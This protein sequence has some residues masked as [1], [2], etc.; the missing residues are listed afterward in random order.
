[1]TSSDQP[2]A[3]AAGARDRLRRRDLLTLGVPRAAASRIA[4]PAPPLED[5]GGHWIRVY[6]AAMACRFEITLAGEDARH[7]PAARDALHEAD[8]LE[9][10]LPGA[11]AALGMLLI[12][13]KE[14]R[15]ALLKNLLNRT[16]GTSIE[17]AT[18]YAA[19]KWPQWQ[20][21]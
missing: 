14:T 15:A 1:M 9:A 7:V 16:K 20:T 12:R 4:S 11:G 2:V 8:R 21:E 18:R 13:N 3:P 6:R 19:Q 10:S 17:E 5:D